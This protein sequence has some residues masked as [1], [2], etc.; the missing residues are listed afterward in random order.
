MWDWWSG[1]I[2]DAT[3][4]RASNHE[5]QIMGSHNRRE[6]TVISQSVVLKENLMQGDYSIYEVLGYSLSSLI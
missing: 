2:E 4:H 3:R 5:L 1:G 6:V